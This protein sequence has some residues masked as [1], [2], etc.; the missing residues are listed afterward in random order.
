MKFSRLLIFVLASAVA[1]A[2]HA[3]EGLTVTTKVE[4][5]G[6]VVQPLPSD[7]PRNTAGL[8]AWFHADDGENENAS[9]V[10]QWTDHGG[11]SFHATE[12]DA[13]KQ[14]TCLRKVLNGKAVI[15][16]AGAQRLGIPSY[17]FD[18]ATTVIAVWRPN[19]LTPYACVIGGNAAKTLEF[20]TDNSTP[21][22][23]AFSRATYATS[24]SNKTIA[25]GQWQVTSWKCGGRGYGNNV[26]CSVSADGV[27]GTGMSLNDCQAGQSTYIGSSMGTSGFLN[28]DIAE[29]LIY[30]RCL[31]A[32]EE[33][34][35]LERLSVKY[36]LPLAD[37]PEYSFAMNAFASWTGGKHPIIRRGVAGAFDCD[38]V[39]V[40]SLYEEAGTYYVTY[41]GWN[42]GV[43]HI[44]LATGKSLQTLVKQ[45]VI[46]S[47]TASAWDSG[48]VSGSRIKKFG[49]TYY[50]YYWGSAN[51]G[52][53]AEPG[54]LGVATSTSP[55]GPYTKS[56]N[57]PLIVPGPSGSWNEKIN[58][59]QDVIEFGGQ[60]L[61]F[62]NGKAA[63][64]VEDIGVAVASAPDGPFTVHA[65]NPILT[66]GSDAWCQSR[67][68]DPVLVKSDDGSKLLM[69]YFGQTDPRPALH[70]IAESSD[71]LSWT[72]FGGN[73]VAVVA[74]GPAI[75]YSPW[76]CSDG[77]WRAIVDD[78][79]QAY[80][81]ECDVQP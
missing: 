45:G 6:A 40:C 2:S 48:Y 58:Y 31:T 43:A 74:R 63:T 8:M 22:K 67:I 57:N 53:E 34:R 12:A 18:D 10:W 56:A 17:F 60:Y 80:A 32:S 44:G 7:D 24:G 26:S 66:R 69:F 68:G 28:G 36:A 13:A 3:A 27:I 55:L 25:A 54:S 37:A 62:F 35:Q 46:L 42:A 70:G 30:G 21:A 77:K 33:R 72:K 38:Y 76:L 64:S 52:F 4:I 5:G 49:A 16:F 15:R 23:L 73:P 79:G 51:V 19:T 11:N 14:P 65:A 81:V 41:T 61:N 59:R 71:G 39:E 78:I 50:L 9:L 20:G 1:I 47:P 29:L 75:R